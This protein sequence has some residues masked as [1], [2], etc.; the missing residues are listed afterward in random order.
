MLFSKIPRIRLL[1]KETPLTPA[2]NLGGYLGREEVYFKRDDV[3]ELG[4]AGNK[5]RSLEFWL[6]E[7]MVKNATTIIVA[8]LPES[9]LCR[10]SAAACAKLGLRCVII[11]NGDKPETL[12]KSVGNPLLNH[13]LGVETLYLG[14]VDEFERTRFAKEYAADLAKKGETP[15]IIGD[16]VVGALGYVNAAIELAWQAERSNIDL[17]DIFISASGGPTSVGFLYGLA[18]FGK[19]FR[20]HLVSAEYEK[21]VFMG[22]QDE[23]FAGLCKKLDLTPPVNPSDISV[24]YDEYLGQGYAKPTK[25]AVDAAYTLARKEGIFIEL[26]YNAKALDGM[27]D[28]LKSAKAHNG[29]ATCYYITGGGPALFGHAGHFEKG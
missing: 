3:M 13:I 8:G 14:K 18:L 15:Y 17:Y 10:L 9:N 4:M 2:K 29:C 5:V 7:A 1:N 20:L 25:S 26:T 24:F 19:S 12:S 27:M 28:F 16:P 22:I 21:A 6:G 11:H 23:I